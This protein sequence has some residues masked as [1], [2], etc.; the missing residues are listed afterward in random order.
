MKRESISRGEIFNEIF[1]VTSKF[2]TEFE[3]TYDTRKTRE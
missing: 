2:R 1:R 3:I